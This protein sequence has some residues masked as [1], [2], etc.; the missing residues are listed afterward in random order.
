MTNYQDCHACKASFSLEQ[1]EPANF[2]PY[3]G[4]GLEDRKMNIVMDA[5]ID[6]SRKNLEYHEWKEW[7]TGDKEGTW[8]EAIMSKKV[9]NSS[10]G[11]ESK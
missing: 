11:E 3:C 6:K 7:Y 2:C 9:Y 10:L 4:C 1:M 5:I 8:R